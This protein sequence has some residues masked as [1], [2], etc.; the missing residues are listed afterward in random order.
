MSPIAVTLTRPVPAEHLE[1][2]VDEELS[3]FDR[4]FQ[5][6]GN[7]PLSAFE[8][9]ILKTYLGIKLREVTELKNTTEPAPEGG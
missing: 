8:R 7:S 3:E 2:A 4:T 1:A 5:A 6:V 9:A